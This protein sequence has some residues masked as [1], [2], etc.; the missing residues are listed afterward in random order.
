MKVFAERGTGG[1]NGTELSSSPSGL[2]GRVG[3]RDGTNDYVLVP[4]SPCTPLEPDPSC[5]PDAAPQSGGWD[6][7]QEGVRPVPLAPTEATIG[8]WRFLCFFEPTPDPER[9]RANWIKGGQTLGPVTDAATPAPG[10]EA[11]GL[12]RV[13]AG[14]TDLKGSSLDR[15]QLAVGEFLALAG[16]WD[17]PLRSLNVEGRRL[18]ASRPEKAVAVQTFNV[19]GV[20]YH[21]RLPGPTAAEIQTFVHRKGLGTLSNFW[22]VAG[23]DFMERHRD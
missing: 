12:R 23:A 15:R 14:G 16:C 2:T 21:V 7:P 11:V 3:G 22:R 5:S 17:V 13:S 1:P 8:Q 19:G 10:A 9:V 4:L 6:A 20:D 18:V